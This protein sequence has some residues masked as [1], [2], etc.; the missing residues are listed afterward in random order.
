MRQ[1]VVH[2]TGGTPGYGDARVDGRVAIARP[3]VD[4]VTDVG[5]IP[6]PAG[7]PA[8]YCRLHHTNLRIACTWS[9]GGPDHAKEWIGGTWV[10]RG[11]SC[12]TNAVIYDNTGLL[13]IS[14]CG[15]AVGSQGWRYVD[16]ANRLVTS[17]E[18]Y[19]DIAKGIFE[20][21]KWPDIWIGQGNTGAVVCGPDLGL[22]QLS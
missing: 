19:A 10:D 12:G 2:W 16:A 17:D 21:T 3:G 22:R 20:Y 8:L 4:V 6:Q 13:H 15:P 14:D 1:L 11:L 7:R 5:S 18:T 9:D